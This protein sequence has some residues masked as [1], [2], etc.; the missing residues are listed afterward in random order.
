MLAAMSHR[1]TDE[2]PRRPRPRTAATG[3][4]TARRSHR[5]A[6][7][8]PAAAARSAG[9]LTG[10]FRGAGSVLGQVSGI[11]V[12]ARALDRL[13]ASTERAAAFLDRLDEEIGIERAVEIIDRLDRLGDLLEDSHRALLQIERLLGDLHTQAIPTARP[14]SAGAQT[15]ARRRA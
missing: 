4:T 15:R 5:A 11:D 8:E 1:P 2:S 10:L 7:A 14:A 3:T 13:A 12:P 6:A 9:G